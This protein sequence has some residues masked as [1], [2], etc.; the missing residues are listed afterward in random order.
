[1]SRQAECMA[2]VSIIGLELVYIAGIAGGLYAYSV[3][4]APAALIGPIVLGIF[5]LLFNCFLC[6]YKD[7]LKVAIAV[8]DAAADYYAA[9][10]R[11]FFVSLFYFLFHIVFI[12]LMVGTVFFMYG[13]QTFV[14]AGN[15]STNPNAAVECPGS[16]G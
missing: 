11:L 8:I 3:T 12:A 5:F 15:V 2:Y 16:D 14:Y 10:K 7:K 6:C 13:S 4:K 1:M 9:T